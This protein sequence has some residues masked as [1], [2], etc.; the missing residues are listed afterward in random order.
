MMR[1]VPL[2]QMKQ[3]LTKF[4]RPYVSAIVDGYP[5]LPYMGRFYDLLMESARCCGI[6]S[7]WSSPIYTYD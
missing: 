1:I 6:S 2:L 7:S 3:L 5:I 4:F